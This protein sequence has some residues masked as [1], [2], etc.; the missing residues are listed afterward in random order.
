[1]VKYRSISTY[2]IV[3]LWEFCKNILKCTFEM[4]GKRSKEENPKEKINS[5]E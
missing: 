1:M 3:F 5:G 2:A 4:K